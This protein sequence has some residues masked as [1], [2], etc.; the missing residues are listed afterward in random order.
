MNTT[1]F[2]ARLTV[3]F[4]AMR[5]V[6]LIA[7]QSFTCCSSCANCQLAMKVEAMTPEARAN[8]KGVV[9]Y[10]QQEAGHIDRGLHLPYGPVDINGS[11]VGLDTRAVGQIV[12][13]CLKEAGIEVVWDGDDKNTIYAKCS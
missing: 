10:T 5:R 3:A 4:K 9:Y 6:G 11:Q 13:T 8:V 1:D 2:K 7:R 12:A